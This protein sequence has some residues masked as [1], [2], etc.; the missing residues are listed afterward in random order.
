MGRANSSKRSTIQERRIL[1]PREG[2]REEL[3]MVG[4]GGHGVV[5]LKP[6]GLALLAL[7]P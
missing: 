4:M 7:E 1:E 3:A 6:K 5:Q 2:E